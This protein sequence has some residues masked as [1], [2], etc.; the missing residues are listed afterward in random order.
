[1]PYTSSEPMSYEARFPYGLTTV[2]AA[3]FFTMLGGLYGPAKRKA[4]RRSA[5]VAFELVATT[6]ELRYILT[7]PS[8]LA[9]TTRRQILTA[10]PEIGLVATQLPVHPWNVAVELRAGLADVAKPGA[11]F[12]SNLLP[13]FHGLRADETVMT[14]L[15]FAPPNA[16]GI[17]PNTVALPSVIR[18]AV[19]ESSQ[20]DPQQPRRPAR[21]QSSD[22]SAELLDRVLAAYRTVGV[23]KLRTLRPEWTKRVND[24]APATVVW[25]QVLSP[26]TLA[27]LAGLPIGSPM[28]PTLML[29]RSKQLAPH[30]AILSTGRPI[31][32][33]TFAG[34]EQ[35][36]TLSP[37]DRLR[38]LYVVGPV[39]SGK[40]TLLENLIAGDLADPEGYG[41]T[42][43]DAKGGNES[44]FERVLDIIPRERIR[45]V[46][47]YDVADVERAIGFN[48]LS[49]DNPVRITSEVTALLDKLFD[50][51][52]SS[53]RAL[54]V[55]RSSILTLADAKMTLCEVSVLLEPGPRGQRFRERV[56][57]R[58]TNPELLA[59]WRW[60]VGLSDRDKSEVAAPIQRRLRS[61]LLYPQL[62]LSLG[63]TSSGFDLDD[64]LAS[65]KIL[66]VPLAR[67]ELGDELAQMV[68]SLVVMKL[69]GA[70]QRRKGSAK[71]HFWFVDEFQDVL[72]H[73]ST[74]VGEIASQVRGY[75]VGLTLAH[76]HVTQLGERMRDEVF[77]DLR[78]KVVFQTDQGTRQL[79]E[80]LGRGVTAEDIQELG[81]YE[82]FARLHVG[83]RTLPAATACGLP[84]VTGPGLGRA[85]RV[86]SRTTFGVS[87]Q[88]VEAQIAARHGD[89]YQSVAEEKALAVR[90]ELE[91]SDM[92]AGWEPWD[93]E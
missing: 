24:R 45:D 37:W 72:K 17:V 90:D 61:L 2:Q 85:V 22:R 11:L 14:Q 81:K 33:S 31:G 4:G 64:I 86:A 70:I 89:A 38:G 52:S 36:L 74:T 32:I 59:F 13:S 49:G 26:E 58:I 71:T 55:L 7:L 69:W 34:D 67:G 39:G 91:T 23:T 50:F 42:V 56:L 10:M 87:A 5:L 25:P 21:S 20:A 12:T 66:L 83:S 88:D 54:D 73:A 27:T 92:P 78:S 3:R 46:V 68:G 35:L 44:L 19:A 16:M 79:A 53:P 57:A 51:S 65:G 28:I 15:I 82:M 75:N 62:R 77:A 18:V 76:Q 40:T 47:V 93:D 48:V 8:H 80:Q 60:Y 9:D 1:M 63:Q 43:V 84:P 6:K 41:L 29:G 30:P